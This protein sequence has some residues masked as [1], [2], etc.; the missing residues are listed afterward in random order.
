M[1][2]AAGPKLEP[3]SYCPLEEERFPIYD[4]P[5]ILR[6]QFNLTTPEIAT[7]Y[8]IKQALHSELVKWHDVPEEKKPQATSLAMIPTYIK[9]VGELREGATGFVVDAG[10]TGWKFAKY[11]VEDGEL[12]EVGEVVEGKFGKKKWQAEEFFDFLAEKVE[13]NSIDL[14]DVDNLSFIF[15]FPG[16]AEGTELGVDVKAKNNLSKNWSIEGLEESGLGVGEMFTKALEK[17]GCKGKEGQ[18]LTELPMYVMN[19]TVAT[20]F[21]HPDAKIGGVVGTGFNLAAL[22]DSMA[23]NLESGD[24]YTEALE[25]L[26]HHLFNIYDEGTDNAGEYLTE[27][28]IAGQSL[29]GQMRVFAEIAY[30]HGHIGGDLLNAV[31]K[32]E[33]N[34]HGEFL[35]HLLDGEEGQETAEELLGRQLKEKEKY[36]MKT[37]YQQLV[38]RSQTV[39]AGTIAG[40][41]DFVNE[42]TSEQEFVFPV[43]GSFF[44]FTPEYTEKLLVKLQRLCPVYEFDFVGKDERL[45]MIGAVRVGCSA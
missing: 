18:S 17:K 45:G 5:E 2:E 6:E 37:I 14:S 7:S 39:L 35:S 1:A 41:A 25:Q 13:E 21:A 30:Q 8:A 32:A 23:Y 10:G 33:K 19:D 3:L 9:E 15:S 26:K 27:K 16:D 11:R 28:F 4:E 31:S 36:L 40:L 34:S 24:F 38:E 42:N 12:A 20:L 44:W 22:I 29:L 43:D